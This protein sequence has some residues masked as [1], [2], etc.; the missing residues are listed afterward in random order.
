MRPEVI[1]KSDFRYN[2]QIFYPDGVI[3]RPIRLHFSASSEKITFTI[4]GLQPLTA[5]MIRITTHDEVTDQDVENQALRRAEVQVKTKE[6]GKI[7]KI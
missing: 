7:Q 6:D 2:Y 4:N 3:S 5:Y 1:G